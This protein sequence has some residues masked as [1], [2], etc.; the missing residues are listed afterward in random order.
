MYRMFTILSTSNVRI[1][2]RKRC[3]RRDRPSDP[4]FFYYRGE[5]RTTSGQEIMI[6]VAQLNDLAVRV[7]GF[8]RHEQENG[9]VFNLVVLIPGQSAS[10][11]VSRVL[12][13]RPLTLVLFLDSGE[14][15]THAVSV[16]THEIQETGNPASPIYRHQIEL[17]ERFPDDG[18]DLSD[19]EE[20]L[21]AIMARF[22]R[23]LD[24]LDRSGVAKREAV[25][26]RVRGM[27]DAAP[28]K[29]N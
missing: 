26:Q 18:P 4:V 28:E 19:I 2:P 11:G 17:A 10:D 16:K 27:R 5:C 9:A 22:E 1:D 23:L 7:S 12:S 20:E 8:T 25:E 13:Q 24:A 6:E 21:A 15:E 29:L 14:K 3:A